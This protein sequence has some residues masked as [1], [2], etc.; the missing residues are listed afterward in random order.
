MTINTVRTDNI[1]NY[2]HN[3]MCQ[4]KITH[5]SKTLENLYLYWKTFS[6]IRKP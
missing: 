6:E 2:N 3:Y 1:V 4:I 5:T